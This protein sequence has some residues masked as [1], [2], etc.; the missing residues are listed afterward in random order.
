MKRTENRIWKTEIQVQD[1]VIGVRAHIGA[2]AL[3]ASAIQL[4][5]LEVWYEVDPTL[6]EDLL[7]LMIVGTGHRMPEYDGK[8]RVHVATVPTG[9]FVWHLFQLV[10]TPG[11]TT[12]TVPVDTVMDF[13]GSLTETEGYVPGEWDEYEALADAAGMEIG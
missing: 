1:G 11:L 6:P 2:R 8:A 5:L 13:V 12:E 10:D 4:D 9:L 3:H 7:E